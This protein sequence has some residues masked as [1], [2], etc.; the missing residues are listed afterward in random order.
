MAATLRDAI[1]AAT[2]SG[3]ER[4]GHRHAPDFSFKVP[5]KP[6]AKIGAGMDGVAR[7][8]A[9]QQTRPRPK[10]HTWLPYNFRD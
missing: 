7:S 3:P 10:I 1:V 5:A 6:I 9:N 8:A 4:G 2:H